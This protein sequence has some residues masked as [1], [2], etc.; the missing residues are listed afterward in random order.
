ML[1]DVVCVYRENRKIE[2]E[3]AALKALHLQFTTKIKK[4]ERVL[5]GVERDLLDQP[6]IQEAILPLHNA[7]GSK[8]VDGVCVEL[9]RTHLWDQELLTEICDGIERSHWPHF[10][11]EVTTLKVDN[12]EWM[13]WVAANHKAADMFT[14]AYGLKVSQPRVK[15]VKEDEE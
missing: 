6:E 15:E 4:L 5:A 3:I 2:M 8:T 11:K 10:I 14:P 13:K 9:R 1:C 12:R 7:G